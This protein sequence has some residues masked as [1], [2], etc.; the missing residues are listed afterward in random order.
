MTSVAVMGSSGS[1]GTQTLDIIRSSPDRFTVDA[2]GVATSIE[3]LIR[4]VEEFRP[5]VAVVA[6]DSRTA[7]A[8]RAL[9]AGTELLAG[10]EG[11]AEASAH[12]DITVNGIMGF[13]G[14]AVTL[15]A[16]ENGKRLGLA[17]KESLI[18]AGPIVQRVRDTPGAELLPIDSEHCD[19]VRRP[20]PR[21]GS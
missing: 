1:I 14:L 9:P 18:A 2:L 10:A 4:Q 6:D 21:L 15:S 3:V 13:A 11:L 19:R 17:N 7:E 20:V 5:R 8:R 16:L 12:A